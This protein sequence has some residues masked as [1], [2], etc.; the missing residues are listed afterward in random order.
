MIRWLPILLPLL[1]LLLPYLRP[2]LRRLD[3]EQ[4]HRP[5][6]EHPQAAMSRTQALE[7]LGLEDGATPGEIRQAHRRLMQKLHPDV[8]GSSFLA[9]QVNRAR[10]ILLDSSP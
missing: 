6:R 8:G 1:I 2:W 5:E 9:T 3:G 10:A 4:G 7:I